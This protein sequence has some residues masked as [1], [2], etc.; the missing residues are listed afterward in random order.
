MHCVFTNEER[1]ESAA[2]QM[3]GAA[4]DWR[5]SECLRCVWLYRPIILVKGPFFRASIGKEH[6]GKYS[7]R[8]ASGEHLLAF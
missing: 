5:I 6:L 4:N 3:G 1:F 7:R 8:S 2:F